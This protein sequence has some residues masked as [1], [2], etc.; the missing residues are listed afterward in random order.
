[1]LL[2]ERGWTTVP[3]EGC[4]DMPVILAGDF[5]VSVKDKYNAELTEFV[6]DTFEFDLLSDLSQGTILESIW[7]LDEMWTI[8]PALTTLHTLAIRDLS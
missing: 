6:K 2:Q 4:E 8:Y 7:S 3:V 5:K 1:L